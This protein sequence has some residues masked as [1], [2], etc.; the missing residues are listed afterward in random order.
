MYFSAF[1][2]VIIP[3]R[4]PDIAR[5]SIESMSFPNQMTDPDQN[6]H[7]PKTQENPRNPGRKPKASS[8][9]QRVHRAKKMVRCIRRDPD[10]GFVDSANRLLNPLHDEQRQRDSQKRNTHKRQRPG[11]RQ[12]VRNTN[13]ERRHQKRLGAD[14]PRDARADQRML[15]FDL[16]ANKPDFVQVVRT[17]WAIRGRRICGGHNQ[18]D[19]PSAL[20]TVR[21]ATA[22]CPDE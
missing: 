11:A 20:A 1:S 3:D 9:P 2:A 19:N 5:L 4:T 10:V 7:H 6:N 8:L 17:T 22:K 14:K 16:V 15:K 18:K 21:A 12:L 13:R